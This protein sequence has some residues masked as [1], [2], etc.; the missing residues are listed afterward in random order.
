MASALVNVYTCSGFM[1]D[2][3]RTSFCLLV[4]SRAN[5]FPSCS[6]TFLSLFISSSI[7]STA[8]LFSSPDDL[9]CVRTLAQLAI[10]MRFM[11]ISPLNASMPWTLTGSH[12]VNIL[13]DMKSFYTAS[14]LRYPEKAYYALLS[15]VNVLTMVPHLLNLCDTALSLIL[16]WNL[17]SFKDIPTQ[18]ITL[19]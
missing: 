11:N 1:P 2:D 18:G 19:C 9:T 7:F 6:I 5:S 4:I 12:P 10:E 8:Y 15:P 13:D 14:I 16:T 3:S 17:N